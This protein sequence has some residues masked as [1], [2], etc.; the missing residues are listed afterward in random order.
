MT[1][2]CENYQRIPA[3]PKLREED[4]WEVNA[5][6]GRKAHGKIAKNKNKTTPRDQHKIKKTQILERRSHYTIKWVPQNK[7]DKWK[8]KK[9]QSLSEKLDFSTRNIYFKQILFWMASAGCQHDYIW[10]EL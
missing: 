3:L 6:L 7:L 9:N 2:S 1:L 5:N 10:D 8:K 4:C